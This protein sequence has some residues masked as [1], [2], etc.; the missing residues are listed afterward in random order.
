MCRRPKVCLPGSYKIIYIMNI[1]HCMQLFEYGNV[2]RL[3]RKNVDDLLLNTSA[4]SVT[5]PI[6]IY[7][8]ITKKKK[9]K[10]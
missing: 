5:R 8:V 3:H 6:V 10:R 2:Y 9:K 4:V 1:V 7:W